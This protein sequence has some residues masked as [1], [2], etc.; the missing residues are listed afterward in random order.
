MV[1]TVVAAV[2]VV[3]VVVVVLWVDACIWLIVLLVFSWV[4]VGCCRCCC[5]SGPSLRV[6][7]G[8]FVL[9]VFGLLVGSL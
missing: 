2:V 3:G 8:S 9:T 7:A 5:C 1:V 4:P 6:V